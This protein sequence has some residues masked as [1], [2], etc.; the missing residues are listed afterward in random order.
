M[1]HVM[2][3]VFLLSE[4]PFPAKMLEGLIHLYIFLGA[5]Q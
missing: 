4:G 1:G 2:V 3:S 5:E